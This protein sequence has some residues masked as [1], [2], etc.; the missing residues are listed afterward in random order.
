MSEKAFQ[1]LTW[2]LEKNN[3]QIRQFQFCNRIAN[4]YDQYLLYCPDLMESWESGNASHFN[5]RK[6]IKTSSLA[7]KFYGAT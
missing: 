5:I 7:K 2:H 4:I 3:G 6:T 1:P